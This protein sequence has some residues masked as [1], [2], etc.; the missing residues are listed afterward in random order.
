M[1]CLTKTR[2]RDQEMVTNVAYLVAGE[3][4]SDFEARTSDTDYHS[5]NT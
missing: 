2:K 1:S 5:Y 4:H 3:K